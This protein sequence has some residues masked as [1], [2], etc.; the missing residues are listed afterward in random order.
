M[1]IPIH[2]KLRKRRRNLKQTTEEALRKIAVYTQDTDDRLLKSI[3][4]KVLEMVFE[5]ALNLLVKI[6][7][8]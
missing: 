1:K 4:Q 2:I 8:V 5:I 3:I 6:P 7:R